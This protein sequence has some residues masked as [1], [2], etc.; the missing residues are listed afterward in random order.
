MPEPSGVTRKKGKVGRRSYTDIRPFH[1][2]MAQ[3]LS[4]GG[5][6]SL[7]KIA[8]LMANA[9]MGT[10]VT[11]VTTPSGEE[12]RVTK[13]YNPAAIRKMLAIQLS[14]EQAARY[15]E[16]CPRV[17]RATKHPSLAR[18]WRFLWWSEIL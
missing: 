5:K 15:E 18:G 14:P 17:L 10:E 4:L 6:R 13:A 9:A 2:F 11:W 1:V 16:L 12:I 7:R 8:S 3:K